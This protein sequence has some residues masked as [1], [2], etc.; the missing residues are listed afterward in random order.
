MGDRSRLHTILKED[1]LGRRHL[2]GDLNTMQE[3]IVDNVNIW[4]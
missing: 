3:Q 1:L 4:D 2:K